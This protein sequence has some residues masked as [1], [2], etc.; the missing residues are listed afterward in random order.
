MNQPVPSSRAGRNLS[1]GTAIAALFSLAGCGGERGAGGEQGAA[2]HPGKDIFDRVCFACHSIGEGPRVGPDLKDIHQRREQDWLVRWMRDPLGMIETDSIGRAILAEWNNVPMAPP[3]LSDQEIDDVLD[4]ISAVSEG[5]V[6]EV[7]AAEEGPIELS[8]EDFATGRRIFFERCAG[9]HGTLRAGATGPN[10]Q[11]ERTSQMG[12]AALRAILINGSPGG[13]PPWGQQGFLTD[14]EIEIM[15]KY[16]QLPPPDPPGRPLSEI[17]SSWDLKIPVEDRPT[18]PRTRRNWEN[19]FGVILRDAGKVA[20]LDGDNY[21]LVEVIQTGYAVHILR[22]SSSGR[23]FYAV[24]RDGRVTLIDLWSEKPTL[25]AQV[26]GCMDARSVDA[27]KYEGYEDRYL[28]EGCYW[29]PQYIVFDG[30]T[31]EPLNVTS[32]EGNTYDTNEPLEEV[33]VASIIASH[34]DPVWVLALKES[35]HVALVDYS[36]DGFPMVSRIPAERFLHDGGWDHTGRY[37]MVAANM[38]NQMVVIDVQEQ[39][40]VTKFETGIKPHPGRGV[41]WEDPDYGWVN[42]T[43]HIGQ[44]L[45]AVY[46]ADPENRPEHAWKVVREIELD[47]T[48]TLFIKTHPNSPWVWVDMPMSNDPEDARKVCVYSKQEAKIHRCWQVGERGRSVHFEY[49]RDGTEVWVSVW[50]PEGEIVV[51]DDKTLEEKKRIRGD[52]L[53]TPTGK[54]NVFNTA[55][56]IY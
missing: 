12:T 11:P 14:A 42:A 29:P 36:K 24:G 4:Y 18:S 54:F 26:Q 35:G 52:W 37:F 34:F 30:L 31:L 3:N 7:A 5:R 28:I 1:L 23:Y 38:R 27:S 41:N 45:I 50:D 9:C 33:R 16:V 40:F 53:I 8:A 51:Y 46:G 32:V 47:G 48:G 43:G 39:E 17:H 55:R 6:I 13:M 56:D 21:Q 2:A 44:G 20:I 19:Y 25:V 22:S 49:N 10:I 15:A